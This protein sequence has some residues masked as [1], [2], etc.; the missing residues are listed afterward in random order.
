MDDEYTPE[1]VS[2]IDDDGSEYLFEEL[3]RIE[4]DDGK[5]IALLPVLED[6]AVIDNDDEGVEVLILKVDE[7]D[8]A[9]ILSQI[10]D[11]KE[12]D[13]VCKIFEERL[14]EFD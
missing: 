10:E 7:D 4:T 6:D 3:D 1:I 11:S 8:G 14:I 12:Y 2:V 5:Y 13:E 9:P